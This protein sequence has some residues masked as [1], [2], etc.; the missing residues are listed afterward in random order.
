MET[1]TNKPVYTCPMHPEVISDVPGKCP[2]CGMKLVPKGSRMALSRISM[3]LL[4]LLPIIIVLLLP[5]VGIHFDATWIL[6]ILLA[7]CCI[8]PMLFMRHSGNKR[9]SHFSENN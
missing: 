2:K 1:N 6:F 8:L 9:G 5:V 7:S 3:L 4:C